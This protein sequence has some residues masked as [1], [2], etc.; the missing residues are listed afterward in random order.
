[1]FPTRLN[2]H[3]YIRHLFP[4]GIAPGNPSRANISSEISVHSCRGAPFTRE[5]ACTCGRHAIILFRRYLNSFITLSDENNR[6]LFHPCAI[7][8]PRRL[9]FLHRSRP[10]RGV[11]VVQPIFLRELIEISMRKYE[12]GN[13]LTLSLR[14]SPSPSIAL[15][16]RNANATQDT[17]FITYFPRFF[18]VPVPLCS[19]RR[20]IA[21]CSFRA[22]ISDSFPT[23]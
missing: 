6:E 11:R 13:S 23:T 9:R 5:R 18:P 7:S 1:M 22:R 4:C 19:G 12:R 15:S 14:R 2:F 10:S 17:A 21:G 16:F 3:L 8:P 20:S